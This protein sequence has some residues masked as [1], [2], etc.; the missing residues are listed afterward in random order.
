MKLFTIAIVLNRH[1][2]VEILSKYSNCLKD[3]DGLWY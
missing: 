2:I 3:Q 1:S